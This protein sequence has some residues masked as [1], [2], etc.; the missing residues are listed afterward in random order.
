MRLLLV[1]HGQTAANVARRLDTARPGFDLTEVGRE[2]AVALAHRLE[3]ER[4][5]AI[6]ASDLVRT[7]QTAA[8]LA[9]TLGLGVVVL[10]GLREI[11][12]GDYEMSTDWGPYV[13]TVATWHDDPTRAIPG[14][15][16]GV[17]FLTR[18]RRAIHR[19]AASGHE[20]AVAVSHGAA[21]RVWCSFALD[22]PAGFLDGRRM[23]NTL[24]VTVEGDPDAGWRLLSWGDEPV[25]HDR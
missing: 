11:Q 18:Y 1:R 22:L 16:S 4:L 7:Q 10:P 14:G 9:A 21:I 6:Y 5:D 17:D 8:P 15:D 20:R 12:A 13:E 23:D 19:I 24:V 2:Q 3:H 25:P